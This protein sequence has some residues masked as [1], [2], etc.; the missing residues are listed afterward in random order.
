MSIK[1]RAKALR[2][3]PAAASVLKESHSFHF[4]RSGSRSTTSSTNCWTGRLLH[5]PFNIFNKAPPQRLHLQCP[6]EIEMSHGVKSQSFITEIVMLLLHLRGAISECQLS[7]PPP[8]P[9][10]ISQGTTTRTQKI[11]ANGYW[12]IS[13]SSSPTVTSLPFQTWLN[14][15]CEE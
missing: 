10:L 15:G 8:P 1:Q 6:E 3:E 11:H 2:M 4:N 12:F 9:S 7:T 5:Q 14:C 13:F